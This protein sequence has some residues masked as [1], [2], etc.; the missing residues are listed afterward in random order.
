MTI[1]EIRKLAERAL[2]PPSRD[3]GPNPTPGLARFTIAVL[4]ELTA[5][6]MSGDREM[7]AAGHDLLQALASKLEHSK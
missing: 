6:R 7:E 3:G 2:Q 5:W 1:D 4:D